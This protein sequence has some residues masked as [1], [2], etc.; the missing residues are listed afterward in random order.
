MMP[1]FKKIYAGVTTFLFGDGTEPEV[2]GAFPEID[3]EKLKAQLRVVENAREEGTRGIP[4]ARNSQ[5][6]GTE[7]DI[8]GKVGNLRAATFRI[9]ERWL[10]Q[11]QARLDGIDLTLQSKHT[12]Q[13]GDEFVRK[14]DSI[15]SSA[16]GELQEAIQVSKSRKAILDR[17]R[18]DNRRDNTPAV[19]PGWMDHTVKIC[20]LVIFCIVESALNAN[21]FASG[22]AGGFLGG[23]VM[24]LTIAVLNLVVTFFAGRLCTNWKHVHGARSVFGL[25]AGIAGVIW[26]LFVGF[27]VAYFRLVMPQIDE[28]GANQMQLVLHSMQALV[29]PFSDVE[30]IMLF[31]I[32]VVCGLVALRHGYTWSDPYPGYSKVYGAYVDAQQQVIEI[33]GRIRENL[34]TEKQN[35]LSQIDANVQKATEAIKT[36]RYNMGEKEVARKKV[37]ERLILAD[38][39]MQS[40]TQSYRYANQMVRPVDKPYPEYFNDPIELDAQ[41][42]P[43]FGLD[44]DQNRLNA[45]QQMLDEMLAIHQPTRAQVQS[46]FVAKFDQ[47]SPL[48]AQVQE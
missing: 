17:F 4:D 35:T 1:L 10:K 30:S 16:D 48:E 3:S 31:A 47:L 2:D 37:I 13:L 25:I 42:F 23:L 18:V 15:L 24:A 12:V 19:L 27:L 45:Q 11:I 39:T 22:M 40:L 26:T 9:G 5:P 46:S 7:L 44:R 36:F 43:D 8:L 41:D 20:L 34:E 32:T 21:F 28:E 14:A 29:S 33:I 6:T 38:K